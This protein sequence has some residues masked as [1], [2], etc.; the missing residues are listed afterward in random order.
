MASHKLTIEIK[1]DR[2]LRI[3]E[4]LEHLKLIHIQREGQ[5]TVEYVQNHEPL[6]VEEFVESIKAAEREI[7]NG[8]FD[9]LNDFESRSKKWD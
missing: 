5:E 8:A 3:L 1:N 2:V 4:D 6:T 9:S 7:D